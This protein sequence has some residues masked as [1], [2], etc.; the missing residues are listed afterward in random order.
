MVSSR[1]LGAAAALAFTAGIASMTASPAVADSDQCP[2]GSFCVWEKSSYRGDFRHY[3]SSTPNVGDYTNDR[4][5]SY[6]NRTGKTVSVYEHSNYVGRMFTVGPGKS[7]A[8]MASHF[9][10]KMMSL[11]IGRGC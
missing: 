2:Y 10:D 7:E 1:L 3:T 6:W 11:R 8:A 5:T 9:N 4:M